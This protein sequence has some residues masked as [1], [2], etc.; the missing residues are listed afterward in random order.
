MSS[1]HQIE[2][3]RSIRR[4]LIAGAALALLLGGAVGG[5][6]ATAPMAGAVIAHGNLVVASSVKQ[7]QHPLGGVIA[8]IEVAE[9]DRVEAGR[10]LMRLDAT[11]ARTALQIVSK[12]FDESLARNAR[13][14]AELSSLPDLEIPPELASR[15]AEPGV[16]A[17]IDGER[18]MMALQAATREGQKAQLNDRI[19]GLE[20]TIV[21]LSDQIVSKDQQVALIDQELEGMVTLLA[22]KLVTLSRVTALKRERSEAVGERGQLT[23]AIAEAKASISAARLQ[24]LQVDHDAREKASR[25]IQDTRV[26]ISELVERRTAAED[27]L[28]RIEI[29]APQAGIVHKLAFHTVGGVLRAGETIMDIVP[30]AEQLVVDVR[31]S[32]RDINSVH[33]GQFAKLR[34]SGVNQRTTPEVDGTVTIV[35]A[36]ITEDPRSGQSYYTARVGVSDDQLAR[37]EGLRPV[38]GMP[39]EVFIKTQ[40]RTALD[41]LVQPLS[42]QIER[43]FREH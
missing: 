12:R 43:A 34:F 14:A 15:M 13:A 41:Y 16:R 37:V 30:L 25:E 19:G 18:K 8:S 20:G 29:R 35:S 23:T 27:E 10:V 17:A 11:Q 9:G 21:G 28:R 24:I 4:H 40:E 7:A 22:R 2:T 3:H 26:E 33:P 42:D 39:V 38:P 32:P 1:S 36:D 6:A 5:W 31:M